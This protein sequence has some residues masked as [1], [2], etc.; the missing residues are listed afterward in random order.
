MKG[1][2]AR[3]E[4]RDMGWAAVQRRE[5]CFYCKWDVFLRRL[6]YVVIL[7]DTITSPYPEGCPMS[8]FYLIIIIDLETKYLIALEKNIEYGSS[9]SKPNS[10]IA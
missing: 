8:I 4:C 7:L 10:K 3:W 2:F 9:L 5:E 6:S 1:S